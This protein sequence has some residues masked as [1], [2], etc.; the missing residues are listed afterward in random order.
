VKQSKKRPVPPGIAATLKVLAEIHGELDGDLDVNLHR[1]DDADQHVG[2]DAD[3]ERHE[4][5]T[6]PKSSPR[7]RRRAR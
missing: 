5:T 3:L 7:V 1:A 4:D 6:S 2:D